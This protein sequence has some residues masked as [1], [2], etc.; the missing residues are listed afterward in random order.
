MKNSSISIMMAAV[1]FAAAFAG[2]A[3]IADDASAGTEGYSDDGKGDY[4]VTYSFDGGIIV[5][6][7]ATD[8]VY[9]FVTIDSVK[10]PE[11]YTFSA[12]KD[13]SS[14][15]V[16]ATGV[17][18]T[19]TKDI[20]VEPVFA[21]DRAI[22][23]LIYTDGEGKT[24][25]MEFMA[26]KA[27]TKAATEAGTIPYSVSYTGTATTVATSDLAVF[28]DEIGAKIVKDA[29]GTTI[30]TLLID[31]YEFKGF[32]KADEKDA[33]PS[34]DFKKLTANAVVA[35]EGTY[36]LV[37]ADVVAYKAVFEKI[38]DIAYM[39]EGAKV[40]T[41]TS[42]MI[43]ISDEKVVTGDI[44]KAPVMEN[45]IFLGWYDAAGD[46]V[47]GYSVDKDEYTVADA[48]FKFTEGTILY[49][50]FTPVTFT[51]TFVYGEDQE[52]FITETVKYG[53]KAIEPNGL[54][55]GYKGWD[56]D[57]SEAIVEDTVIE[58]IVADP[59]TIYNV[60]F[61]IEGKTPVT[62][63]SDSLVVPDTTIDGKV[64]KGWVVKGQTQ[65][66]DPA[67]Y[68]ITGDVTFVAIY[69][70][71]PAPA[72]PGFFQT[73]SGQLVMVIIAAVLVAFVYA[74]Y[75]NMFG[76]KDTLASFKLQRVRKE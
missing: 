21:A 76:L 48:T 53:E 42:N 47:I 44:P 2:I 17:S 10:V 46:K 20:I 14:G 52:V 8:N 23:Q 63:K 33:T 35:G 59:V 74:V 36:T 40:M 62:Q 24:T 55:A 39:V 26:D 54:P 66:V 7:M 64:F 69:D 60:T 4:T 5:K 38:Y 56:F 43:S 58:A 51:V 30:T 68:D 25:T 1:I 75:K 15:T 73:T 3:L 11:G 67:K 32:V 27:A 65:Y 16:Y 22:V 57:F 18:Y 31:G 6:K 13:T 28:A 71:A 29:K 61:E 41:T 19:F 37:S 49:A 12:W 50:T 9:Q 34:M 70:K 72:G 45:Y